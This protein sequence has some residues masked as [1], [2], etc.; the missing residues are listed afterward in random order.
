MIR[1]EH[2]QHIADF[3]CYRDVPLL[4][5]LLICN[6]M[7]CL[8]QLSILPFVCHA[9]VVVTSRALC[10]IL[11]VKGKYVV[12]AIIRRISR[13]ITDEHVADP[14]DISHAMR[15][16][17]PGFQTPSDD[18]G[19]RALLLLFSRPVTGSTPV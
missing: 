8:F 4:F 7:A 5:G 6:D 12:Y 9:D 17:T 13:E 10:D 3:L 19:C 11:V 14:G 18:A 1:Q 16:N 2:L 15:A